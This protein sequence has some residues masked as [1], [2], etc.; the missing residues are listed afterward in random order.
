MTNLVVTER[1]GSTVLLVTRVESVSCSVH[2]LSGKGHLFKLADN[3][4]IYLRLMMI[5]LGL[6]DWPLLHLK[7]EPSYWV[8]VSR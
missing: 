1:E 8:K 5:Y 2:Y 4:Q 3:L 7:I 6:P